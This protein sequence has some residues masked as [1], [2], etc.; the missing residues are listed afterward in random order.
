[1]TP[2]AEEH[3][4]RAREYLS[5]A[6]Q[7]LDVVHLHDEAARAAYLASFHAAQAL[8]SER[9]GRI[10]KTHRGVRSVFARLSK[11]D[12]RLD[13]SFTQFLGRGYRRK[14]LVDYGVGA[15]TAVPEPDAR[16]L[17]SSAA[18]FIDVITQVL[19]EGTR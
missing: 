18:R 16:E 9:T 10:A 14:E 17:T 7:L 2:E 12:P 19:T 3:L 1:V 11:G 4:L 6:N 5:K 8:I 15:Q 13:R